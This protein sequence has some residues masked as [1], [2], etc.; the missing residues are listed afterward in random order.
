MATPDSHR[1]P[2][3]AWG[4]GPYSPTLGRAQYS[5]CRPV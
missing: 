4:L 1:H 2:V 3:L 5:R